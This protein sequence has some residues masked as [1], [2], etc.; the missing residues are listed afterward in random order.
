MA[1]KLNPIIEKVITEGADLYCESRGSGPLLLL[2]TG[3]MGDAGFYSSAA[4]M[5][6]NDFTVLNY[7]R[8]CNSRSTGDRM[9]DMT[10]AQQARDAVAIIKAMGHNRAIIFGS[11][12]GGIIGLELAAVNPKMIDFLIIHEPPVIELLPA[13]DAE[14]WRTFHY[15]IY[16]KNLSEGWEAA[17]ADFTASL[18]GAPDIPYPPD[19]NER[20]SQ[21]MDFFFKHEYKAFTQYIPNVKRIRENKVNMVAAIGLDSDDAYYVQ[22]TRVLASRLRCKCIEFPGQHDVSFYMPQEFADSIRSTLEWGRGR[23][24]SGKR[25]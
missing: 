13:A 23:K 11:S 9:A 16:M 17:T 20:I 10:V 24:G 8:R 19:L 6:A 22:S 5:L 4:D 15:N 21:N 7:D 3:G 12:G 18:I 14:K 1:M 2:I 25:L